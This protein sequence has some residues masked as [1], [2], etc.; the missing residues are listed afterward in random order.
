LQDVGRECMVFRGKVMKNRPP[1]DADESRDV[2]KAS[3]DKVKAAK[4]RP[5]PAVQ[6]KF[7]VKPKG[8]M[9]QLFCNPNICYNNGLV[10]Q[11][12]HVDQL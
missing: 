12:N 1:G 7:R 2:N 11:R 10:M 4:P 9:R 8:K 5:R 6:P 3:C